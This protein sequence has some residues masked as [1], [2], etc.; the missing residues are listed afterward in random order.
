MRDADGKVIGAHIGI[1][2]D[3]RAYQAVVRHH[4]TRSESQVT[5]EI[6]D[7]EKFEGSGWAGAQND[8]FKKRLKLKARTR[9]NPEGDID[10]RNSTPRPVRVGFST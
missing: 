5:K 4:C 10:G 7:L 9:V 3:M 6:L 8:R 2:R 1:L